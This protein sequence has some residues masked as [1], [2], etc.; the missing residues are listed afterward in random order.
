MS[1]AVLVTFALA[2][3]LGYGWKA[4]FNGH[5]TSTACHHGL[6]ERCRE[7][8]KHCDER[9]RCVCHTLTPVESED[10]T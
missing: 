7:V 10:P 1:L 4:T 5:Y 9:C 2:F 6:H 8:C 3:A